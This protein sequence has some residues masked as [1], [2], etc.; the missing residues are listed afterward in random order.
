MF[1]ESKEGSKNLYSVPM[2][3]KE[4]RQSD[5]LSYKTGQSDLSEIVCIKPF[6]VGNALVLLVLNKIEF[7]RI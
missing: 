3:Q 7:D 5:G 4:G 1:L 6:V 2:I